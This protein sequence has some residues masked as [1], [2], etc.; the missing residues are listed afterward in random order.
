[1]DSTNHNSLGSS[2]RATGTHNVVRDRIR[3]KRLPVYESGASEQTPGAFLTNRQQNV[4]SRLSA[5]IT[6]QEPS[7]LYDEDDTTLTS[8]M[9][10]TT[11]VSEEHMIDCFIVFDVI[12]KVPRVCLPISISKGCLL[13]WIA[14]RRIVVGFREGD[15]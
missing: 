3:D 12:R 4:A 10:D 9:S 14:F 2:E 6:S 1:M 8:Y 11:W 5:P 13:V 15:S 7:F